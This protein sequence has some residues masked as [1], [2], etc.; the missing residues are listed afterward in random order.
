MSW[1]WG[2]AIMALRPLI[3]GL[4][5]LMVVYSYIKAGAP[6][7]IISVSTTFLAS[8]SCMTW[9]NYIDRFHDAGCG[10]DF[11]LKQGSKY[12]LFCWSMW[13]ITFAFV[14]ILYAQNWRAGLLATGLCLFGFTYTYA[15][16]VFLLSEILVATCLTST[17]FFPLVEGHRGPAWYIYLV[18]GV[19]LLARE[20]IKNI[21]HPEADVGWKVTVSVLFGNRTAA[22]TAQFILGFGVILGLLVAAHNSSP[23]YVAAEAMG[24]VI[25]AVAA[26]YLVSGRFHAARHVI[27]LGALGLLVAGSL[28]SSI[29]MV[30]YLLTAAIPSIVKK[31]EKQFPEWRPEKIT[32]PWWTWPAMFGVFFCVV[33]GLRWVTGTA[34]VKFIFLPDT[35]EGTLYAALTITSALL[36]LFYLSPKLSPAFDAIEAQDTPGFRLI[37]RVPPGLLLAGACSVVGAN[38]IAVPLLMAGVGIGAT[39][40]HKRGCW[41]MKQGGFLLGTVLGLCLIGGLLYATKQFLIAYIPTVLFYYLYRWITNKP[42]S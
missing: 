17:A 25:L 36:I 32:Q 6:I 40:W 19:F 18:G 13:I 14:G 16:R 2:P 24:M 41:V 3:S 5:T 15:R 38:T 33:W 21:L 31:S 22:I 8:C 9:N 11:A 4:A 28:P 10:N 12:L 27:D 29:R 20:N 42:G 26:A 34:D 35:P 37:M 30:S 39:V 23:A 7:N 1:Q